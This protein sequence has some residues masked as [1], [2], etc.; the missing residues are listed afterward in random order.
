MAKGCSAELRG[1]L[2]VGTS[3]YQQQQVKYA[4]CTKKALKQGNKGIGGWKL[5]GIL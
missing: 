3:G 1:M 4:S 5:G 2:I